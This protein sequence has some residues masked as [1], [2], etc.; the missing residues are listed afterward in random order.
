MIALPFSRQPFPEKDPGRL[1]AAAPRLEYD[2]YTVTAGPAE[3]NICTLPVH[4]LNDYTGVR[5]GV[6][7]DDGPITVPD[8]GTSGRSRE[9]K[10][11]VLSNT[12]IRSVK[13][14][15]LNKGRHTLIIYMIDPGVILQSITIDL[16]G[17]KKAYSL[18]PETRTTG[19]DTNP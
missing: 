12:A 17:L 8:P 18:I 7:V 3:I 19:P 2:F 16:G 11:N 9:W 6:S 5:Y 13:K 4:P 1:R 14:P 15:Y 10:L